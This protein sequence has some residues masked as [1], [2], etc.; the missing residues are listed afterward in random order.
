MSDDI[1]K[2]LRVQSNRRSGYAH[3]M[4]DGSIKWHPMLDEA[5]DEIERPEAERDPLRAELAAER[6]RVIEEC[7]AIVD[8]LVENNPL[9]LPRVAAAIRALRGDGDE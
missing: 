3:M 7:A 9:L 2:R 1:V 8:D 4:S 5:D 6:E